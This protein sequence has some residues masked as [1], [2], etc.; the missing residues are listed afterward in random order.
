MNFAWLAGVGALLAA[1]V[2]H[3]Q[4]SDEELA[5][6][7]ANPVASLTSVPF[8]LNYDCC[9]GSEDAG[10][11][12]LNVQPVMPF[13]LS[14]RMNLIVRTI[15]P[16]IDAEGAAPTQGDEFG[17]GDTTQTFFFS[18]HSTGV[19]WAVGPAALW[20]TASDK[21][22][23]G[24]WGLGP[25]AL[26]LKQTP[27]LTLG[28]LANHIWSYA[29]RSNRPDVSATFIQP[30]LAYKLNRTDTLS[31]NTESTYDWEGSAWT[32][33]INLTYNHLTKIGKQALQFAGGA[34]YYAEKPSGGAEWGLRFTVT[35]AYP[36]S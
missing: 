19:T 9:F 11:Y 25:S 20:P 16:I 6:K 35:L 8:Q 26:V 17:F 5:Q 28:F 4:A 7:L 34:K 36:K 18:P 27:N 24:K 30:F 23:G 15:A 29:G 13:A 10:R 21:L 22:G 1:S 12:T 32:V 31:L 2:A 3:A 33:P 14:P